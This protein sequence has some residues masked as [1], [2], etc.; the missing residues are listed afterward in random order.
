MNVKI[1]LITDAIYFNRRYETSSPNW[2]T[3]ERNA[4]RNATRALLWM[5]GPGWA[6]DVGGPRAGLNEREA[7][8]KVVTGRS[9]KRLVQLRKAVVLKPSG[10]AREAIF[11]GKKT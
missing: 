6:A 4:G 3:L 5:V 1:Y 11:I 7:P 10:V 2:N 8:G 9:P